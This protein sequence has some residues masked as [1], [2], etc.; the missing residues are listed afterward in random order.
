MKENTDNTISDLY[1]N[2]ECYYCILKKNTCD[3]EVSAPPFS[4]HFKHKKTCG[5]ES[6]EKEA[7]PIHASAANLLLIR[8]GSFG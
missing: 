2:E 8:I 4:N 3:N 6:H 7:K 1:L 5:N